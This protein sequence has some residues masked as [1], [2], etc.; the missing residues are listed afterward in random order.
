MTAV[1][2]VI[3]EPRGRWRLI[4]WR[5]L[6]EYRDL[7]RFLVWRDVKAIYKQSVLGF[8]WAILQP[9]I[10]M[11]LFTVVFGRLAGVSTDGLP[12][13][14]FYFAALVPWT[15]LNNALTG[16]ANSLVTQAN[17]LSKVYVPRL[18]IPL[19]PVLAKLVDF[20]IALAMLAALVI[21]YAAIDSTFA[22]SVR[23]RLLLLP[24]AVALMAL[25]ASGIGL[26]LAAL[27]V[28]YRDVKF[29]LPF[30][31]Q[32]LM[33]AAPVVWPASLLP[34]RY[35]IVA[36]LYPMFGTIEAFRAMLQ[37]SRPLAWDLL[38]AGSVGAMAITLLGLV[39]Y[40]RHERWFA[41]VA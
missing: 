37:P 27:A 3:I 11:V 41:D 24:L 12:G 1:R 5:E 26:L 39:V 18:I 25:T 15:Y 17:L 21:G 30:I 19:T 28:R 14:L 8:G 16:S 31:T 29:A 32:V 13:P 40:R 35:R 2:T 6:L 4:D 34:H 23:P 9:L 22:F 7:V 36:G 10:T 20:A 38:A 33:Y